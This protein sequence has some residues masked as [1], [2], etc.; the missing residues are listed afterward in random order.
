MPLGGRAEKRIPLAVPVYLVS[1]RE[2]RVVE[3][4]MTE[5]VSP[6]GARVATKRPWESGEQPRLSRQLGDYQLSAQVVYCQA[7]MDGSYCLGL[8]FR[9]DSMTWEE[10]PGQRSMRM[11]TWKRNDSGSA[12]SE[13]QGNGDKE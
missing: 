8:E 3:K 12:R 5:N 10:V 11:A 9:S 2:L 6:H 4:A 1:T 13:R 7:L